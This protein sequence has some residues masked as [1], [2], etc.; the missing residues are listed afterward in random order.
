MSKGAK[1]N[2][3]SLKKDFGINKELWGWSISLLVNQEQTV[4]FR[5]LFSAVTGLLVLNMC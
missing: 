2:S 3:W 4:I 5:L 1:L